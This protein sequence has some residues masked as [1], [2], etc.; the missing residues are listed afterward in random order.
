M[1]KKN[2]TSFWIQNQTWTCEIQIDDLTGHEAEAN[3]DIPHK[4][5]AWWRFE[6]CDDVPWCK[7]PNDYPK[8][9]NRS[10]YDRGISC[11]SVELNFHVFAHEREISWGTEDVENA[12]K[13]VA[14][15]KF[16]LEKSFHRCRKLRKGWDLGNAARQVLRVGQ[17][18][19]QRL[20]LFGENVVRGF[21]G[22]RNV[23]WY[24]SKNSEMMQT[25]HGIELGVLTEHSVCVSLAALWGTARLNLPREASQ[26]RETPNPTTKLWT[27]RHKVDNLLMHEVAVLLTSHP[28]RI[29]AVDKGR[30]RRIDV[31][32]KASI[33][34][35]E[36]NSWKDSQCGVIGWRNWCAK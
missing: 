10:G 35:N 1:L 13:D 3:D 23:I 25:R 7:Q 12:R 34:Q 2:E 32:L 29:V 18:A 4:K 15:E 19:F 22:P 27:K 11:A 20:I 28:T 26:F 6:L 16:V 5:L 8:Y 9:H 24:R 31:Y 33:R 21:Q 36:P 17:V 14:H 30:F